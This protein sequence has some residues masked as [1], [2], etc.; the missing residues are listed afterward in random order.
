MNSLER[1]T[2]TLKGQPVDRIPVYPIVNSVSR[3]ILGISYD[4][5][6]NNV[7]KCAE[8][9]IG[10]TDKLDLDIITTLVDLSVEAADWGQEI[11]FFDDKAGC[12]S[13]NKV[14]KT[15]EDYK[16]I[17]AID[18]TKT[19]RMSEHIDLCKKLVEKRGDEKPIIAFLFAPLGIASMLRG[20]SDFMMD[21][22]L[23]PQEVHK[24]LE[25]ITETMIKLCDAIIDTGV[26]GI[27]F[28][29]LF[30]SKT[31]MSEK[32]WD[33]FEGP[34]IERI[35]NHVLSRGCLTM[36]H[37]CG[38][39]PYFNAQIK[40]IKPSAFSFLHYP[41]ECTSYEDMANKYGDK[42]TL[43]GHIHP[44]WLMNAT[45]DEV[46]KEAEKEIDVFKKTKSFIL[47]TGCEYPAPLNFEKAEVIVNVA[48][49]YG[50]F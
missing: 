44:G 29:T 34:Y 7:E 20:M 15:A 43:I 1:V 5:W 49:T 2:A 14:I 26:H 41:Y 3:K 48:K 6:S 35:S 4:E 13:E 36:I 37:N 42:L 31:I 46:K 38:E 23:S 28:D 45:L 12:P 27:M 30:A 8:S 22:I 39:G 18:P 10:I 21:L 19:K 24:C 47:S 25:E 32:M 16:N 50:K 33:E 17:K 40:R 11:L 9:I